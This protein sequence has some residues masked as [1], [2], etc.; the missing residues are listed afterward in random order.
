MVFIQERENL[1]WIC[2]C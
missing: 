2:W 1:G